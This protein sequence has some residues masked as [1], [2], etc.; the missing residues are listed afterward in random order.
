MSLKQ[1]FIV[2]F[3]EIVKILCRFSSSAR[4]FDV[5][6]KRNKVAPKVN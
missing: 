6:C 4:S 5:E 2:L 3:A 1:G